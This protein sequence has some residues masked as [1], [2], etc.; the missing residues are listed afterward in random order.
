MNHD[1]QF[2]VLRTTTR[3][4]GMDHFYIMFV[5]DDYTK[6]DYES[7]FELAYITCGDWFEIEP[8]RDYAKTFSKSYI[9][10]IYGVTRYKEIHLPDRI[11][12]LTKEEQ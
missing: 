12:S 8:L 5:T 2:I 10:D 6:H 3:I 7:H 11:L 9:G 4:Q 1:Y